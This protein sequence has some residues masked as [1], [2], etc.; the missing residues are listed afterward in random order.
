MATLAPLLAA[1]GDPGLIAA[2]NASLS[3][4]PPVQGAAPPPE[5]VVIAT[6]AFHLAVLVD[7]PGYPPSVTTAPIGEGSAATFDPLP[8][9]AL[10]GAGGAAVCAPRLRRPPPAPRHDTPS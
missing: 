6:E 8:A 7:V 3:V 9:A 10:A 2:A 5:P 4:M 1:S